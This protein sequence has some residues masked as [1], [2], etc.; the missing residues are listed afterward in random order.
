MSE[1]ETRKRER[2]KEKEILNKIKK[3]TYLCKNIANKAHKQKKRQRA[4]KSNIKKQDLLRSILRS[5]NEILFVYVCMC[6]YRESAL[7][8]W[9]RQRGRERKRQ[10][11]RELEQESEFVST[12]E[13]WRQRWKERGS[14]REI[15]RIDCER[16]R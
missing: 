16:R 4:E 12:G 10:G 6:G 13:R 3:E 9:M 2:K 7:R 5:K 14:E 1:K 8:E 15:H 11:V